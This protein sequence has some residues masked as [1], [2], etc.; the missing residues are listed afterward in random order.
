M[1]ICEECG[2]TFEEPT[3]YREYHGLEHGYEELCV[4]PHCG[5]GGYVEA[6]ECNVCGQPIAR[7]NICPDCMD[8]FRKALDGFI[9]IYSAAMKISR[10][11]VADLMMD[12]IG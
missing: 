8:D 3:V 5:S 2:I 4:C 9:D 12:C 10:N 7:G 6:K 11:D 1:F